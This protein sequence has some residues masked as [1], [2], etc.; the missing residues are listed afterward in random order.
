MNYETF[1]V[2]YN[3]ARCT[4]KKESY[5]TE[6]TLEKIYKLANSDIQTMR[7]YSGYNQKEFS[8]KYEI[9]KRTLQDWEQGKR[10]PPEYTKKLLAYT[11]IQKGE[12]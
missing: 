5:A 6:R 10:N 12:D 3:K 8:E 2:L 11:I 1:S 9:P 4:T 7:K